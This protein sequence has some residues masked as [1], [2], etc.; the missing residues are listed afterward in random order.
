MTF[1]LVATDPRSGEVGVVALTAM[2][3]VGKLVAHARPRL[4]AA[5]SQ[6]MMNPY[7]AFDGLRLLAEGVPADE[8]LARL[9]E[10]DPGRE[11]RQFGLVD[12]EGRSAS[13]TGSLPEDWKGH[14]TGPHFAAQ[15]NRLAGP[16]VL[17]AAVET[18]LARDDEPLVDRLLAAI[19]AGEDQGGDTKGHRSA[20]LVVLGRED[21]PLWDLR[22]DD[23]D[24]PLR[25]LHAQYETFREELL[26]EIEMLPKRDDPLGG[27][28]YEGS[29]GAV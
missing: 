5:A 14:R 28:D 20:T 6:A 2:P 29:E 11:G 22:I 15:G 17:D 1:S 12:L 23:A 7:L 8:A 25:L 18:F 21:Y 3:G 13:H 9:V 24:E 26:P 19:D 10:G 27:F 16:E 4:G